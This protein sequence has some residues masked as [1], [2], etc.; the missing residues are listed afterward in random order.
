MKNNYST[1]IDFG[2]TKLR[3]GVFDEKL[4]LSYS[5]SLDINENN[6]KDGYSESI[7]SIIKQ[8]E[9]KISNHLENITILYDTSEIFSVDL[10]I[11]KNFD[12]KIIVNDV[13]S[14]LI[15]EANQLIKNNY[16]NKKIIHVITITNIIDGKVIS[17]DINYNLKAN[18]IILDIKFICL[19][20]DKFNKILNLFKLNNLQILNFYCS[21]YIKSFSYINS[22][23]DNKFVAFLDIGWQRSTLTLFKNKKLNFINSIPLGGNNITKDISKVMKIEINESEKIKKAFNKSEIE[24]SYDQKINENNNS[25]IKEI[26]GKN[27]SIDLIKKVV[28]ARIEEIIELIFKELD[29]LKNTNEYKD[30][31][32]VLTGNGSKLFNKNSFHFSDKYNFKEINFYEESDIEICSAGMSFR[33]NLNNN[34]INIVRKSL[35]KTGIFE[36]FFNFFSR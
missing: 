13:Y 16:I 24:F 29:F 33:A 14:S 19:P 4:N 22:F 8:A 35:K 32:L 27:I 12:Q 26:I 21:S 28:L 23:N 31:I 25:I 6:N 34:N 10:S 18:S 17:K 1:I 9:K 7:K 5:S 20:I 3:L 30:T 11:R 36:K 15:S 2:S